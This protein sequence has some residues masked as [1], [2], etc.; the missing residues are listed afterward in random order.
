MIG[1]DPDA[2]IS[3]EKSCKKMTPKRST[4]ANVLINGLQGWMY[5]FR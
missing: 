4:A 1:G 3:I 2:A 5:P